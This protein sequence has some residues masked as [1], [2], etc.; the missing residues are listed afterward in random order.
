MAGEAE[1]AGATTLPEVQ[2]AL[3]E[4]AAEQ[5]AI[6]KR[7]ESLLA[8]LPPSADYLEPTRDWEVPLTLEAELFTALEHIR[9]EILA[10]LIELLERESKM[11]LER[12][13]ARPKEKGGQPA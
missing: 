4:I 13:Q 7:L 8:A 5:R 3:A 10:P 11:T 2:A 1:S 9:H 6:D 12:L